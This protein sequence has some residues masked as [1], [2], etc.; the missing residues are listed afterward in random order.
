ML[1]RIGNFHPDGTALEV[2]SVKFQ[3]LLEA[4]DVGKLSVGK[5]LGSLLLPIFDDAD[6]NDVA[7]LEE[8]GDSVHGRVVR[9]VAKVSSVRRLIGDA[10]RTTVAGGV[11]WSTTSVTWWAEEDL[12]VDDQD[13]LRS[14]PPQAP[15]D[16]AP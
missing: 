1:T 12:V 14:P 13:I 15:L 8:L 5:T 4:I 11:V 3:R 16:P 7:A 6:V 2:L 9:Q 10:S